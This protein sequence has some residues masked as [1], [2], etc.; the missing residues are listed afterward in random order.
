MKWLYVVVGLLLLSIGALLFLRSKISKEKSRASKYSV[1]EEVM[2]TVIMS[3]YEE[4]NKVAREFTAVVRKWESETG[5]LTFDNSGKV[6]DIN[7]DPTK[8][9]LMVN[10]L[11]S[12]GTDLVISKK[13]GLNWSGAFCEGDSISVRVDGEAVLYVM[14]NGYR[15]CGFKGE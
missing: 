1:V 7:I 8:M 9:V 15:R 11:K 14:N 4:E 12:S 10:S 2:P 6:G 5:N 3:T 13:E